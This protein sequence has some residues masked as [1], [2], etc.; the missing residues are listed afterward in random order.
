MATLSEEQFKQLLA[1]I[2]NT[3][4]NGSHSNE[5]RGK[6]ETRNNPSVLGPMRQCN[7]GD[8]KMKK[9]TIFDEWLEEAENR[10]D[11]I[12]I[13]DDKEKLILLKT[14]GGP[15]VNEILKQ[16]TSVF[17]IKQEP[18]ESNDEANTSS[19]SK[20]PKS[21]IKQDTNTYQQTVDT[22]RNTLEKLVNRTM[23]VHRLMTTSQGD[24]TWVEFIKDIEAK[25]KILNFEK[26]PYTQEEAIK[27]AAIFGMSDAKLR[28]KALAE[29]PDLE[30]LSR[31]GH[32]KE[33][34]REDAYQMKGSK[35]NVKKIANDIPDEEMD[36]EEIED[37]IHTLQ[38]MK[39]KKAGKY[40]IRFK[41]RNSCTRCNSEHAPERCPANGRECFKCGGKNHFVNSQSC[42][43]KDVIKRIDHTYGNTIIDGDEC[44]YSSDEETTAKRII[45]IKKVS[46]ENQKWVDVKIGDT[47]C[48]LFADTGSEHTIIPP[49]MYIPA[50]GKLEKSDVHLRAW[51][52]KENLKVQGMLRAKIK[53][54]KGV[55]TRSKIYIV[56]GYRPEPLLGDIDAEELGFIIFNREGKDPNQRNNGDIRKVSPQ[57]IRDNIGVEVET[58]PVISEDTPEEEL[59][60]VD[61]LVDG[62]KGL[63]FDDHKIGKMNIQP[64]HL[65]YDTKFE[66]KQPP[67]RNVP[68]HYQKEVSELLNF[69][70]KEK[71]ITDV[72]PRKSYDCVMNVVITDKANGQIRMNIDNTPRNPGMKRTKFHVQTPQEIRHELVEAEVFSEMD[73]GWGFH[74]LPL[75][76]ESKEKTIFQTHEGL[77]RMER[78]YFGPTASSGIF[79]SEVRKVLTGSDANAKGVTNIHDNILVYGKDYNDHYNN[80]EDTLAKCQ[81]N[82]ITLKLSKSTFCMPKIKWFGRIFNS[83]GVTV[84]EEKVQQILEA[85]RPE[86][87][88]DVRSLLMACQFNAKFLLDNKV[89]GKS[90]EEV[91]S[92]LRKLLHNTEPFKWGS[93]EE[94][95][96]VELMKILNDPATLQPF[97]KGRKTHVVADASEQGIQ[98]SIYQETDDE[99]WIPIDHASRALTETES[100]YSP[101]ER[102]SLALSWGMEQFRYYLVGSNF[103]TWTD[104]E[105]LL[106]I[107]NNMQKR[108]SKRISRHRDQVQDLQYK[109]NYLRGN[110]MPCDFGSRHPANRIDHLSQKEK[111]DLG[112]DTG[113]QIH[114]MKILD[115]TSP[116]HI[117]MEEIKESART[118]QNY[119]VAVEA[120]EKGRFPSKISPYSRVWSELTV[121]EDLIYKGEVLVLPNGN[122]LQTR[123]LEIAH[124]GHP[125]QDAFKRFLRSRVWF[126]SMDTRVETVVQHCL[127]CQAATKTKHRDPLIPSKPP[128][129]P[130]VNLAADHWGP[131]EDGKYVLLVIDE[132]T[133][134]PEAI[135]VNSTRADANIEAFDNIFSR[136]GY[137][138]RLKTDG[139][140]PFNGK[141]NHDLQKYFKWAGIEHKCTYSAEDPEANG[142]AE[143]FMKKIQKIWHTAH[144]ERKNPKAELNKMLQQ[145]RA[146][147]H[148]T[149]GQ[150][151][152]ELLFGRKFRTRLPQVVES[153]TLR[154]KDIMAAKERESKVKEKQKE[155]KDSKSYVRHHNLRVGEK[156]LLK[157][158]TT[159]SKPP[160]DP[161]A[162]TITDVNGHQITAKRG[163]NTKTRDAQRW[164]GI[165]SKPGA[166]EEMSDSDPEWCY[167]ST[168]GS[169]SVGTTG[170]NLPSTTQSSTTDKSF[171]KRPTTKSQTHGR[172]LR[173]HGRKL[174]WNPTMGAKD[175]IVDVSIEIP[176]QQQMATRTAIEE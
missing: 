154:R 122:N 19:G 159:K 107:Y 83:K 38:V 176:E 63:V 18:E 135:V 152:A 166:S 116:N 101:I 106:A 34:G 89:T 31:W 75:A 170:N 8:D 50:M 104:H 86:T 49:E 150:A 125:G 138:K 80:L 67:Y 95:A 110:K 58:H 136:H 47:S 85:G 71:V 48:R 126:P 151:P 51:G 37:M 90:Y 120:L 137:C 114:V 129:E 144:I 43:K 10:M 68:I 46:Q 162:F 146:T 142:L 27:D 123:M 72:D 3:N 84:D 60:R 93:E 41:N 11:F 117:S 168:E 148:P 124:E 171:D 76:D 103:A 105:P 118:D 6:Q 29:D 42:P 22:I 147:P 45:T 145:Y 91:T 127:A 96:Y 69:L 4:S 9:L 24:R 112:F 5:G 26:K 2:T 156:A 39:L 140:P 131:T 92:A 139:G 173:S 167:S 108:T 128:S 94:E 153:N 78:L 64:I 35:G 21:I 99:V 73:M 81:E 7:L 172:M 17:R 62:Y 65:D 53:T 149:T 88:E 161:N 121:V 133:R 56:D 155:A 12:G 87:K 97:E 61:A 77:H 130:W 25:A 28:E 55:E 134:Y 163:A 132:L 158:N 54:P 164:K 143:A 13:N 102:E 52:S 141:E 157:Q 16:Q 111:E 109:L 98:S 57:E 100:R 14:W 70:R 32:A 74:Q 160:Y 115:M 165:K 36:E 66:P 40:S 1:T 174:A 30:T 82:G 169:N 59:R 79:H 119:E 15:D 20:L 113:N 44:R 33:T 23:A 175:A